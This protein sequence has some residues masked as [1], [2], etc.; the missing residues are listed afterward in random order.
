MDGRVLTTALFDK[1]HEQVDKTDH[2][3]ALVPADRLAW[4][5]S[6]DVPLFAMGHLVGHLMECLA[7]FC[8]AL[9]AASPDRLHHFMALRELP[10]KH[11]MEA[12]DARRQLSAY[13]D[14]IEEGFSLLTDDDLARRVP[15]M[16]VAEGEPLM[17][18]LL[19][20]LEHFINH[21]FQLF[22]YLKLMG[23]AVG[24]TDLYVLRGGR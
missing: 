2:L 10:V 6:P 3:L 9:Y 7:G 18:L 16:F 20:N 22:Q 24:T 8:A 1:I 19:G 14:H 5:P 12:E 15:T 11:P 21:K 13:F 4:R 23:L 17:T